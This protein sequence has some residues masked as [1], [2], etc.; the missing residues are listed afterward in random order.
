MDYEEHWYFQRI[1]F[2]SIDEL[3]A[4]VRLSDTR[5]NEAALH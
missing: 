2:N 5:N 3:T 4:T 1:L